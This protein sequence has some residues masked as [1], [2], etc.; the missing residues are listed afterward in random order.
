MNALQPDH[1]AWQRALSPPGMAWT[2]FRKLAERRWFVRSSGCAGLSDLGPRQAWSDGA[3]GGHV[4]LRC[5][6]R[7]HHPGPG[8][9]PRMIRFRPCAGAAG[10]ESGPPT[11][12]LR[13]ACRAT[14]TPSPRRSV[15]LD[16][17]FVNV[18][19]N[20]AIK[21]LTTYDP[22]AKWTGAKAFN[23]ATAAGCSPLRAARQMSAD[24]SRSRTPQ[25]RLALRVLFGLR[26]AQERRPSR[27]ILDGFQKRYRHHRPNGILAASPR[28][29]TFPGARPGT[30]LSLKGA[31]PAHQ[32]APHSIRSLSCVPIQIC[33]E[34]QGCGR[35]RSSRH[36]VVLSVG[37]KSHSRAFYR[38]RPGNSDR[39][40]FDN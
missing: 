39:P 34:G 27:S 5:H 21:H 29:S 10:R 1:V 17:V 2:A 13:C 3:E 18:A 31:D 22:I 30:P 38:T 40:V 4:G 6:Y 15:Q 26:C 33:G 37:E 14:F 28:P 12:A 11:A 23:R 32:L 9:G 8:G 24:E 16:T 25:W 19:P 35:P 7:A 36:A 20:K